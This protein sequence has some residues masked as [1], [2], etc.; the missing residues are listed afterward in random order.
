MSSSTHAL[1]E[2]PTGSGKS[3]ALLCAVLAWHRQHKAQLWAQ[4]QADCDA[5]AAATAGA[6]TIAMHG[7][8]QAE[9]D[10]LESLGGGV[11]VDE[12][13]M[14]YDAFASHAEPHHAAFEAAAFNPF[15][16][17]AASS[18]SAA[19]AATPSSSPADAPVPA[20][21]AA[22]APP[23]LAPPKS[24]RVPKIFI[25]SRTHSQLSQLVSE[26]K[27]TAYRPGMS[28]LG[29]R[30]QY[31][32]NPRVTS[33][34]DRNDACKKLLD[35]NEC[36]FHHNVARLVN[37]PAI[38]PAPGPG[39]GAASAAGSASSAAHATGGKHVVWDIEE[40]VAMGTRAHACPYFAA[41]A[42]ADLSSTDLVLLPYNYILDPLISR[43]I[44]LDLEGS[45]VLID[46]SHNVED[47]CRAAASRDCRLE[48]L[49][50]AEG[51]LQRVQD[52]LEDGSTRTKHFSEVRRVVSAVIQW[53]QTNAARIQPQPHKQNQS[54]G[55]SK[56]QGQEGEQL[57]SVLQCN[58]AQ[59]HPAISGSRAVEL[60]CSLQTFFL[61]FLLSAVASCFAVLSVSHSLTGDECVSFLSTLGIT[62]S[63]LKSLLKSLGDVVT[64]P[65]DSEKDEPHLLGPAAA[66]LE[67][68]GCA[69]E[70]L[71][72]NEGKYVRDYRMVL[73]R[74]RDR[75]RDGTA[76]PGFR[77]AGAG[78]SSND[79]SLVLCFWC[80]NPAVAFTRLAKSA[81]SIILTSGTLSPLDSFAS[82]LG[83][84]FP[85]KLEAP[86]VIDRSQILAHVVAR[87][88]SGR[89]I[90]ASYK[91]ASDLSFHDELGA[92]IVRLVSVTPH[93]VLVF[94]PS[95]SLLDKVV[96]RWRDA[97]S[98][99]ASASSS[100]S[101]I[102]LQLLQHKVVVT[103]PK[104]N[105]KKFE[106]AMEKFTRAN[107]ADEEKPTKAKRSAATAARASSSKKGRG[108]AGKKRGGVIELEDDEGDEEYEPNP[109]AATA[110][111]GGGGEDDEADWLDCD[112]PSTPASAAAAAAP[113]KFR[114]RYSG[115]QTGGLFLAVARGKISEGIDFTDRAARA[116]VVIG[117]PYPSAADAQILEKKK[118]NDS[119]GARQKAAGLAG[120]EP[121]SGNAWYNLQAFRSVNQALGRAI[122]HRYDYGAI[123]L[124][125]ERYLEARN[126]TSLSKWI[127]PCLAHSAATANSGNKPTFQT[128]VQ[129][130]LS[131]DTIVSQTQEF[132]GRW[133]KNPPAPP[134]STVA[135][136]THGGAVSAGAQSPAG[137]KKAIS[138][139]FCGGPSGASSS[140][141]PQPTRPA[142]PAAAAA[143]AIDVDDCEEVRHIP[144]SAASSSSAAAGK[145]PS[146][147]E[148]VRSTPSTSVA[149]IFTASA[150]SSA[151]NSGPAKPRGSAKDMLAAAS[152]AAASPAAAAFPPRPTA[153]TP[154]IPTHLALSCRRCAHPLASLP[155]VQPVANAPP[156]QQSISS[157][158]FVGLVDGASR[159]GSGAADSS[160]AAVAP[161]QVA[162]M[163]CSAFALQPSEPGG[164][165]GWLGYPCALPV[166]FPGSSSVAASQFWNLWVE[167]D[168]LCYQP[169]R[170]SSCHRFVGAQIMV[171]RRDGSASFEESCWIARELVNIKPVTMQF[172]MEASASASPEGMIDSPP[173]LATSAFVKHEPVKSE[174]LSHVSPARCT[175][176]GPSLPLP[177]EEALE[178]AAE[179]AQL[180]HELPQPHQQ[181]QSDM[182]AFPSLSPPPPLES[183]VE[184]EAAR[185]RNERVLASAAAAAERQHLQP[186][187]PRSGD[188]RKGSMASS[189]APTVPVVESGLC[190]ITNL[191]SSSSLPL[192]KKPRKVS[193]ATVIAAAAA[194]AATATPHA[195]VG[196]AAVKRSTASPAPASAAAAGISSS[197]TRPCIDVD[198]DLDDFLSTPP[199]VAA[200]AALSTD[201]QSTAAS[202]A[203]ASSAVSH[204]SKPDSAPA[205]KRPLPAVIRASKPGGSGWTT[206]RAPASKKSAPRSFV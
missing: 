142:A 22:A 73:K 120:P 3:L 50:I 185:S 67:A 116:V 199:A 63:T 5:H 38:Q 25:A 7:D 180:A 177:K 56:F 126:Q 18:S 60:A 28:V 155:I 133:T 1:L 74:E 92:M 19:A 132:F 170:C 179:A 37:T 8:P 197:S 111:R 150:T 134:G 205:V 93:G 26:L 131:F 164:G 178:E 24:P 105:P 191:P 172:A 153:P 115:S 203:P 148:T 2:S 91:H 119:N 158:Y 118:H 47:V 43:S 101:P 141:S 128:G 109:S 16:A 82:E 136:S 83:T 102:W 182:V 17:S 32:I 159:E 20:A 44:G 33:E 9:M 41:R 46:E 49:R 35:F 65:P 27:S 31:C 103:E 42:L 58:S 54:Q 72:S 66:V 129:P 139:F 167:S 145:R 14:I 196:S 12:E 57:M 202:S 6:T 95:Y 64:K 189:P 123:Y 59:P 124:V 11:A 168:Q 146:Q 117:I 188:K 204:S 166:G 69:I 86:H 175:T 34:D 165:F 160:A 76:R 100:G 184:I 154:S 110:A 61:S 162:A 78:G 122:R 169:L 68:W 181:H 80:L 13:P 135:A 79:E 137:S 138:D 77:G 121:I 157:S 183:R 89:A 21:A 140:C 104:S 107:N 98:A 84:P 161:E 108:A 206:T 81:R 190:D 151:S 4:H 96:A 194:A 99:S 29:S 106:L 114:S 53:I 71:L 94:F 125:D 90:N 187:G 186:H 52:T 30:A 152:S 10:R 156:Y 130:A 193:A 163:V 176:N 127:Q 147:T 87:G 173:A 51:E 149:S 113:A 36:R 171:D 198:D 144:S 62:A 195:A 70:F 40:L 85:I 97:A 23:L 200:T 112:S 201:A 88:P 143:N 48:H 15:A 192:S 45:V 39:L 55:A 174:P 75:D